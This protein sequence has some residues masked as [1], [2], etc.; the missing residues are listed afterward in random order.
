M[1]IETI[2]PIV[3][4]IATLLVALIAGFL[5]A[6]AVVTMPGIKRLNDKDFI[7]AFQVMDGVIQDNSPLFGLVW[8]GSIVGMLATAGLGIAHLEGTELLIVISATIIYFVAVQFT[9]IAFNIPLNNQLQALDV[10]AMSIPGLKT[11]RGNFEDRWNFW[12]RSRA[13]VSI[14]VAVMLLS[15]LSIL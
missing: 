9:T 14:I 8:G 13:I 1:T 3:L 2:F 11:A 7:R 5:F 6:F 15:L 10:N 12:N 4:I